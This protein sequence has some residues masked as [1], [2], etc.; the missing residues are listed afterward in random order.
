MSGSYYSA[1]E[2]IEASINKFPKR[3][4]NPVPTF[5]GN[6]VL[7]GDDDTDASLTIAVQMWIKTTSVNLPSAKKWLNGDIVTGEGG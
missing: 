3:L 6:L 4:V 2:A 5:T 7:G 1:E